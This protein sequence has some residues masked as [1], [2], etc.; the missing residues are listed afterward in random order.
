MEIDVRRSIRLNDVP[1]FSIRQWYT[2]LDAE[3][4]IYFYEEDSNESLWAL[5]AVVSV[6]DV[7]AKCEDDEQEE[8]VS[9]FYISIFFS[10]SVVEGEAGDLIGCLRCLNFPPNV[11]NRIG[12]CVRLLTR[13]FRR[14]NG[15]RRKN[16]T[17]PRSW[18]LSRRSTTRRALSLPRWTRASWRS[19][20][21]PAGRWCAGGRRRRTGRPRRAPWCSPTSR[22]GFS[23]YF[24]C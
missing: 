19:R 14:R 12:C 22:N 5:P 8:R 20:P 18:T 17:G 23:S 15:R 1:F 3:G 9:F 11:A 16:W 6:T 2:S 24:F 7:A 10:S 13:C 21:L 4:R